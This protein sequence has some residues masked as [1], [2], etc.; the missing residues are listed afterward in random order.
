M[1]KDKILEAAALEIDQNGITQFRVKR[2]AALL[3]VSVPLLYS[4]FDSREGLIAAGI[5]S[6]YRTVMFGL[7]EIFTEPLKHVKTTD[8]LNAAVAVM[9]AEAQAP[10]RTTA[11]LQRLEGLSFAQHNP[12]ASEGIEQ[13]KREACA[14]IMETVQGIA[15]AGLLADGVSGVA[16]ARIW[17]ALFFGQVEIE[18][19]HALSI[20]SQAW[21]SAL[22]VL[23]SATVRDAAP[24]PQPT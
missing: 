18:G 4:Y 22:S 2:V 14:T 10:E 12:Q 1:M 23:G 20:S 21:L 19:E 8:D 15:D 9:I 7:V 5:L 11:R 6:R 13:V 17:Y 3:G 16:F 24:L